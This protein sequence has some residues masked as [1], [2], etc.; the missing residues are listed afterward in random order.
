M[1]FHAAISEVLEVGEFWNFQLKD[2]LA[3]GCLR[4]GREQDR[5]TR[6]DVG[7]VGIKTKKHE[8]EYGGSSGK[9]LVTSIYLQ[10]YYQKTSVTARVPETLVAEL[11]VR[12]TSTPWRCRQEAT[13]KARIA[14]RPVGHQARTTLGGTSSAM[15]PT[16]FALPTW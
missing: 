2:E 15:L 11:Y 7:L 6:L 9:Q 12:P 13:P 3:S 10:I 4:T 14:S 8:Y 5:V 16:G 1:L